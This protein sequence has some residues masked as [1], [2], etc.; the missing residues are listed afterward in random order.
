MIFLRAQGTLSHRADVS[1]RCAG[2]KGVLM[3]AAHFSESEALR[4][5]TDRRGYQIAP[6]SR[7]AIDDRSAEMPVIIAFSIVGTRAL[8]ARHSPTI[9]RNV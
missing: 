7:L 6:S 2:E 9:H 8:A 3:A 4:R 5:A 1:R